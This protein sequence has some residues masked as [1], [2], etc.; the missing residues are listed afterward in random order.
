DSR[1]HGLDVTVLDHQVVRHVVVEGDAGDVVVLVAE[2][3]G[4]AADHRAVDNQVVGRVAVDGP[5]AEVPGG[6]VLD[7][8]HLGVGV[9][10]VAVGA[11]PPQ[12]HARLGGP[13]HL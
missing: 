9:G 1:R 11:D 5:R 4:V 13:V 7:H 8:A 12:G 10:G 6:K 2:Q 3:A